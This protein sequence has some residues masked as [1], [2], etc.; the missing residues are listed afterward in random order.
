[1]QFISSESR[2]HICIV[3]AIYPPEPVISAQTSQQIAQ[4]LAE[5]GHRVTVV[6]T[7]PSRPAGVLYPGY[8]RRLRQVEK[9]AGGVE[10]VRCLSAPS[11]E[12]SMLSRFWENLTFGVS[13]ALEVLSSPKPNVIYANTWPIFAGGLLSLV[14][15]LRRVPLALSV[16]DVYP[17]SLVAQ[18]RLRGQHLFVR[19]LRMLD[20]W[21]A[22]RANAV[23]VLSERFAQV[24]RKERGVPAERIHV[25]PNWIDESMLEPEAAPGGFREEKG[26]PDQA[27]LLVYG[28]NIGVAAG[29]ETVIDS[30]Q[31]L[32][33]DDRLRF[34]IA[35][36]GS[37]LAACRD[38]AR[39]HTPRIL[40][41]S[42]W[43]QSETG[44][45]LH[46]ADA[47]ILP[48]RGD[49]A[50]YSVPSKLLAYLLAARPVIAL[51]NAGSEIAHLVRD[52]GCGWVVEPDDPE[53][54]ADA[55]RTVQ[56]LTESE[57]RNFGLA[58]RAYA[59]KNMGKQVCLPRVLDLLEK[60]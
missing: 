7:F 31:W 39:D 20:G 51:A 1:M 25:V 56:A 8:R 26:I 41:H 49:Q 5:R 28:G 36:E 53:K 12:S 54:L 44:R 13:S 58:G 42:P 2:L 32:D 35:G 3:T 37:R 17:E 11:R 4:G 19:L 52:A 9:Q 24:Y 15:G 18:G 10:I 30:F 21:I 43:L 55:L 57:R 48:T 60:M 50:D 29:V 6:T 38:L 47:L 34:L 46:A 59:L 27:F 33:K 22:R 23:I 14:A 40:F 45:V 16:Q